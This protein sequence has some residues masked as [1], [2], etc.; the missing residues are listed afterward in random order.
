MRSLKHDINTSLLAMII[1]FI[2]LFIAYTVYYETALRSI[3]HKYNQDEADVLTARA[4]L[5]KLNRSDSMKEI[6]QIDKAIME[7]KYNDLLSKNENLNND[8]AA[9][10]K[11]IILLKSE[12]EYSG[13]KSDGPVAQFRLIQK[14]NEQIKE[15]QEKI[16][17]LCM[18]LKAFNE[19]MEDC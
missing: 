13:V 12:I 5:T 11:E 3:L 16:D 8:K 1:F 14:K 7:E 19:S 4:V 6:A 18:K 10:Q 2:V 17:A 15:L 9:L